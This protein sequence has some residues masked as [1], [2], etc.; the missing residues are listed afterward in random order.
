MRSLW[1]VSGNVESDNGNYLYY[2]GEEKIFDSQ[3]YKRRCNRIQSYFQ[4]N[5]YLILIEYFVEIFYSSLQDVINKTHKNNM[6]II[7]ECKY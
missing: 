6:L 2:S 3:I 1:K 5:M 7:L 4:K